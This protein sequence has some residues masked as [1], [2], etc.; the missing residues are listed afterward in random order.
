MIGPVAPLAHTRRLDSGDSPR[1]ISPCTSAISAKCRPLSDRGLACASSGFSSMY[2]FGWHKLL[3]HVDASTPSVQLI[4][5]VNLKPTGSW[6]K[7][8]TSRLEI[9]PQDLR[10]MAVKCFDARA[11][12]GKPTCLPLLPCS[13]G[14]WLRQTCWSLRNGPACKFLSLR[15]QQFPNLRRD[16]FCIRS[17]THDNEIVTGVAGSCC[18]SSQQSDFTRVRRIIRNMRDGAK[19][20][21]DILA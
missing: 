6:I 8:I 18:Q 3:A 20:C 4:V 9:N 15:R 2:Q 1:Q 12:G 11:I 17:K 7:P 10:Q 16:A 19:S 14:K 21:A 5:C 13:F